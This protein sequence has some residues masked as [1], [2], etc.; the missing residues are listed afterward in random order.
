MAPTPPTV[1]VPRILG[2]A[3][4]QPMARVRAFV[5]TEPQL[6]HPT[7]LQ[8][9]RRRGVL[10]HGLQNP[11]HPPGVS[12]TAIPAAHG[13]PASRLPTAAAMDFQGPGAPRV[14]Q[15]PCARKL[16]PDRAQRGQPQA[17]TDRRRKGRQQQAVWLYRPAQ[18]GDEE[19]RMSPEEGA[20]QT[21]FDGGRSSSPLTVRPER[22]RAPLPATWPGILAC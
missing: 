1:L 18:G 15:A 20:P 2:T 16:A 13:Q 5:S 8:L 3:R 21:G 7:E 10:Q 9:A 12:A 11:R 22:E 14:T 6:G 19:A 17:G 4:A